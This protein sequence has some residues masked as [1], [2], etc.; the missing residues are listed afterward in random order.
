MSAADPTDIEKVPSTVAAKGQPSASGNGESADGDGTPP[1]GS[2]IHPRWL[3]GVLA[4]KDW[5][6]S[7]SGGVSI[8]RPRRPRL[9]ANPA[10]DLMSENERLFFYASFLLIANLSPLS[11]RLNWGAK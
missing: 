7:R 9:A 10:D 11:F 1:S 2:S 8:H 5:Q 6:T 4:F 3:S